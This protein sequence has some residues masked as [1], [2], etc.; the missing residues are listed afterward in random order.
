MSR[1]KANKGMIDDDQVIDLSIALKR[2]LAKLTQAAL[3]PLD[4]HTRV[5][6]FERG[7]A[8]S[9]GVESARVVPGHAPEHDIRHGQVSN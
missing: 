5:G 9:K 7:G 6:G 4:R 8:A 3:F 2:R 1:G